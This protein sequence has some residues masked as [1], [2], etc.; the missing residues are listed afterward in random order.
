MYDP[1]YTPEQ[2]GAAGF[3]AALSWVLAEP[4]RLD[5]LADRLAERWADPE[6][7]IR[8]G[9]PDRSEDPARFEE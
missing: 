7:R 3:L 1:I 9:T 4:D 8:F 5:R 6:H 2:S